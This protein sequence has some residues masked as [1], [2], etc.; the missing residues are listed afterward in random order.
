MKFLNGYE[1][2]ASRNQIHNGSPIATRAVF[3]HLVELQTGSISL[4]RLYTGAT[5]T[6]SLFE[7]Y[8]VASYNQDSR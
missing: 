7:T 8:P 6:V 5:S 3:C 1:A 2:H 4:V